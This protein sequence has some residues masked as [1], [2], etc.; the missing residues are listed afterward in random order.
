MYM[1]SSTLLVTG[2]IARPTTVLSMA[3]NTSCTCTTSSCTDRSHQHLAL[4]ANCNSNHT[5]WHWP[6]QKTLCI[7]PPETNHPGKQPGQSPTT[8]TQH[9]TFCHQNSDQTSGLPLTTHHN[10]AS[11]SL[12]SDSQ[13]VQP[14]HSWISRS[15]QQGTPSVRQHQ[16][17]HATQAMTP[18]C[19]CVR[20]TPGPSDSKEPLT[21]SLRKPWNRD[22]APNPPSTAALAYPNS[23]FCAPT[24]LLYAALAPIATRPAPAILSMFFLVFLGTSL[25]ASASAEPA[26]TPFTMVE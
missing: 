2:E 4:T 9:L 3:F 15:S 12:Q 1:T 21:Q 13:T 8:T 18:T 17:H 23:F 20:S 26:N 22:S 25:S 24:A 11:R 6:V 7:P 10:I 5:S 19:G 16:A 14:Q